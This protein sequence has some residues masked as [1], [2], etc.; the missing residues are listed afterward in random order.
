[1]KKYILILI[2]ILFPLTCL[3]GSIQ[4]KHK[5]VIARR[6]A[7]AAPSY[8]YSTS[9]EETGVET[10]WSALSGSAD[11]D[12]A[13][14]GTPPTGSGSECVDRTSSAAQETIG[15]TYGSDLATSYTRFYI[16]V[17]D[18]LADETNYIEVRDSSDAS[19][20][21]S[22]QIVQGGT[23]TTIR[24]H[25]FDDG[26][27]AVQ[28]DLFTDFQLNTWY[29]IEILYDVT[30]MVWEWWIDGVSTGNGSLTGVVT[31]GVDIYRL[32]HT[33]TDTA[34]IYYDLF[35]INGSRIGCN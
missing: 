25:V 5:A 4:D 18:R 35:A 11:W 10:G 14:P 12:S 34:T 2:A 19:G 17:S 23:V 33:S 7:A 28:K 21:K 9:F 31:S 6:N 27:N 29:C 26:T 32:G 8:L 20:E 3:A 16:Y 22:W 1:M 24:L 15:Y 13:I 30:G